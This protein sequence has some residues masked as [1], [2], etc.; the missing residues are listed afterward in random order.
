LVTKELVRKTVVVGYDKEAVLG[1]HVTALAKKPGS[2]GDVIEK[3]SALNSGHV[4]FAFPLH[5]VGA[6]YFEFHGSRSGS[7]SGTITV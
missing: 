1:T 4:A 2:D 7:D 5:Y 3:K 6:C